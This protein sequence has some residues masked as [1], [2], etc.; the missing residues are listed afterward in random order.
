MA[1][2][3]PTA[4]YSAFLLHLYFNLIFPNNYRI[5]RKEASVTDRT[6]MAAAGY[7]VHPVETATR[8]CKMCLCVNCEHV[9][10]LVIAMYIAR[11]VGLNF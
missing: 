6:D 2:F 9:F 7:A 11:K 10:C 4:A 8:T 5:Q 3:R 1:Q